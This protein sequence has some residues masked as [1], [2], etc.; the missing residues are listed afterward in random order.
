MTTYHC[1]YCFQ[2]ISAADQAVQCMSCQSVYH[3]EHYDDSCFK[4]KGTTTKVLIPSEQNSRAKVKKPRKL[5]RQRINQDSQVSWHDI[6]H[7]INLK[8]KFL[9]SSIVAIIL[10]AGIGAYANRFLAYNEYSDTTKFI[11]N[12]VR[13]QLPPSDIFLA[14]F[15]AAALAAFAFFPISLPTID[16]ANSNSR[17]FARII[18]SFVLLISFNLYFLPFNLETPFVLVESILIGTNIESLSGLIL[19]NQFVTLILTFVASFIIHRINK[20]PN[21]F[22]PILR[23]MVFTTRLL[24]HYIAA[25]VIFLIIYHVIEHVR[26]FYS[27]STRKITIGAYDLDILKSLVILTILMV[28]SVLYLAPKRSGIQHRWWFFRIAGLI[29][30]SLGIIYIYQQVPIELT[31]ILLQTILLSMIV[32]GSFA[33]VFA[34]IS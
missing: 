25:F 15:I 11:N 30:F 26:S 24:W 33:F 29:V 23:W 21:P 1:F 8:A 12:I 34:E 5:A 2:P 17:R 16:K 19:Q 10:C 20:Q 28:T 32:T 7:Y 9:L 14:T 13:A 27:Q 3:L 18:A 6:A 31:P 4:C 22:P